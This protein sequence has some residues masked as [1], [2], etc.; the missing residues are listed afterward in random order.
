MPTS[1]Y[2]QSPH[3]KGI[4]WTS[5]VVRYP[6]FDGDTF[7]LAWADDGQLY[8]SADDTLGHGADGRFTE[9]NCNLAIYRV[10]GTPPDH[11]MTLVNPMRAFG[12][13]CQIDG[14]ATWKANGMTCVDGVL[15]LS[16]SQHWHFF[17]D[18]IQRTHDASILKSADHGRTWSAK[19]AAGTGGMFPGPHFSTPFFVKFGQDNAGAFD[20]FVYAASNNGSWNNGN[21]MT[22]GRVHRTRIAALD[23]MDWEFF[24]GLDAGGS[25]TWRREL[26]RNVVRPIT[27]DG[28]DTPDSTSH[29]TP[30]YR[31]RGFTGMTGMQYVPAVRRFLMGQWSYTDLDAHK[32]ERTT[33]FLCEAERPWGPWHHVHTEP[34][35]NNAY[36]GPEFP[37]KWFE[38]DG[39]RLWMTASG[40]FAGLPRPDY[41]LCAQQLEL[42]L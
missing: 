29:L 5:E 28:G 1:P 19:P 34:N 30:I 25:P 20:D 32:F 41:S 18:L 15:Y 35:W 7:S 37:A 38:A 26:V 24:T 16:V 17:P 2:P 42:L 4:R 22:L 6:N 31:H 9:T 27:V 8:T 10:D 23:P 40:S 39:L 36:Y 11:R 13:R 14:E 3:I 12:N 21:Y 33:L